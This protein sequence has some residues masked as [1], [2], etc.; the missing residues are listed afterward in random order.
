MFSVPKDSFILKKK[1]QQN[2]FR[3]WVKSSYHCIAGSLNYYSDTSLNI[4]QVL[5]LTF[6]EK[7]RC[8][9][10]VL[11]AGERTKWTCLMQLVFLSYKTVTNHL[12]PNFYNTHMADTTDYSFSVSCLIHLVPKHE[13][14]G[15][16]FHS[17]RRFLWPASLG[18][19]AALKRWRGQHPEKPQALSVIM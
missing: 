12:F 15:L 1:S 11:C 16:I 4:C 18:Y 19:Y 3:K 9:G 10:E 5:S 8:S 13:M 6:K 7:K 2:F 17:L 14:M